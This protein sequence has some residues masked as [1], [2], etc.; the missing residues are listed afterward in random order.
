KTGVAMIRHVFLWNVR[1]AA[2]ADAAELIVA[3]LGRL[4]AE[5]VPARAWSLGADA[6]PPGSENSGGRW[7]YALV[8]DYDSPEHL[9]AYYSTPEHAAVVDEILPLIAE[10]AVCDFEL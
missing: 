7:Q 8:C 5:P 6:P 4:E 10:R 1:S 9:Q 2:R 3:A